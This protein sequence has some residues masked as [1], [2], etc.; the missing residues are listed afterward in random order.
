[1]IGCIGCQVKEE[2]KTQ[3]TIYKKHGAEFGEHGEISLK[4]LLESDRLI[5]YGFNYLVFII[6]L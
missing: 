3:S 2:G 5:K 4:S 6:I 1:L